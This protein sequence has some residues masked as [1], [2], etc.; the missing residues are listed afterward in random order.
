MLVFIGILAV[1]FVVGIYIAIKDPGLLTKAEQDAQK[2][3][4]EAQRIADVAAK[5]KADLTGKAKTP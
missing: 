1:V 3:K 2:A 5:V 4:A